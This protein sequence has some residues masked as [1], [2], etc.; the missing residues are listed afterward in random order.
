MQ[1]NEN[2]TI[3]QNIEQLEYSKRLGSWGGI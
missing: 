1:M 2:Y 3:Q